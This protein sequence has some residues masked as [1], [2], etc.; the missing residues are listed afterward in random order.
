M[1]VDAISR[2][3]FF[4]LCEFDEIEECYSWSVINEDC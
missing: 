1:K 2:V 4:I 3:Y